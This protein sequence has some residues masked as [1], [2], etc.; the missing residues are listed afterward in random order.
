[1][2]PRPSLSPAVRNALR[3]FLAAAL[4]IAMVQ[5]CGRPHT[6]LLGLITVVLFCND[7]LSKP[8]QSLLLFS[9][10]ILVGI[11][12]ALVLYPL[13]DGWLMLSLALLASALLVRVLRL[14]PGL[15]FAYSGCWAVLVMRQGQRFEI[16]VVFDFALPAV[17]GMLAALFATWVVWPPRSRRRLMELDQQL[18][19]RFGMQL[20]RLEQW[21]ASGGPAPPPLRS[22][23]LL[24]AIMSMQQLAGRSQRRWWQ[25]A[26]LWRQLLRQWLLLEPQLLAV[27][28]QTAPELQ[29]QRLLVLQ[30]LRA[31]LESASPIQPR[32]SP[33][34]TVSPQT[35]TVTRLGLVALASQLDQVDALQRSQQLLRQ[36][37]LAGARP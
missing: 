9:A 37:L 21:L 33:R 20:Q 12:V 4:T 35:S 10:S 19:A 36:A 6:L 24:P 34:W 31:N 16:G 8:L 1:M 25:L 13:S 27:P 11:V 7:S 18:S 32:R 26:L 30:Q 28:P 23:E 15:S 14:N 22:A 29:H 17:I 2:P 3:V 5:W